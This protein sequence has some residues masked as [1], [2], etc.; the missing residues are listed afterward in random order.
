MNKSE[1]M[2]KYN[3][4]QQDNGENAKKNTYVGMRFFNF[5]LGG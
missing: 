1:K 2:E 4:I 3:E 5:I